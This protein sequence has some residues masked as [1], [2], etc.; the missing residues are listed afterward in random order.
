MRTLPALVLVAL[1]SAWVFG[2]EARQVPADWP[3]HGRDAGATRYSPLKQ[4]DTKNVSKLQVAW[5]YDTRVVMPV[6][7]SRG[8]R[9]GGA[10]AAAPRGAGAGGGPAIAAEGQGDAPAAG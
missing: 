5:T 10:G 4:I 7:P 2:A 3:A 1:V 9:A 8:A 6:E